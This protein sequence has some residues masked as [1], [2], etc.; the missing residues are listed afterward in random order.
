MTADLVNFTLNIDF[1]LKIA[2]LVILALY[3]VYLGLVA[4]QVKILNKVVRT[5]GGPFLNF[6]S[7]ANLLAAILLMMLVLLFLL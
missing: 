1:W 3:T 6:F 5:P 2:L 4:H 7:L